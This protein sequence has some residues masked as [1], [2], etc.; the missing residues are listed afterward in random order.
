MWEYVDV[1]GVGVIVHKHA[2]FC[3]VT[4]DVKHDFHSIEHDWK[5]HRQHL[6]QDSSQS[7][8]RQKTLFL[9]VG[10]LAIPCRRSGYIA[11]SF[12]VW[13]VSGRNSLIISLY[14]GKWTESEVFFSAREHM[15]SAVLHAIVHPSVCLSVRHTGG[16]VKTVEVR[17]NNFHHTVTTFL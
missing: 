14:T 9:S 3:Q 11:T 7:H 2:R 5:Y 1:V 13:T 6:P 16:S 17:M 8:R 15:Q 12:P 10:L 4:A